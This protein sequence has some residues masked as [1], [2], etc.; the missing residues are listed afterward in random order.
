MNI[1]GKIRSA[2]KKSLGITFKSIPQFNRA[3]KHGLNIFSFHDVTDQPSNFAMEYGLA[4]SPEIFSRQVSWIQSN[5]NVIHPLDIINN[6]SLPLQAA[7]ITFDDG[8]LGSFNN[9]LAILKELNLPSVVF[10][11]MKAII[12]H[13]PILSAVICYLDRYVPQFS[14]YCKS[15]G[16]VPPFHLTIN[17]SI[18]ND[19]E[20]Q[21]GAVDNKAVIEYQGIFA[22]LNIV[23]KWNDKNHVMFGNHLFDHWNS[24]ALSCEELVDE[25]RRNEMALNQLD[26]A[27]NLFAFPNGRFSEREVG[28]LKKLGAFKVFT[29]ADRVNLDARNYML[30]RIFLHGTD[31]NINHLWFRIGNA[32]LSGF[33]KNTF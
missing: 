6:K 28:C 16:L 3:I 26:N 2:I 10:L 27:I 22:D 24:P 18:L 17:E 11:N 32:M 4:V 13:K 8:F 12:E 1:Q 9:G 25:Y 33:M 5:F 20:G 30:G 14:I 19:F 15:K 21:Y 23:K 31:Y 7:L 29:S